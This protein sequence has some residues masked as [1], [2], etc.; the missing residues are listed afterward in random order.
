MWY[1][2]RYFLFS[3]IIYWLTS[4]LISGMYSTR[5]TGGSTLVTPCLLQEVSGYDIERRTE[6]CKGTTGPNN[7]SPNLENYIVFVWRSIVLLKWLIFQNL[8]T[9]ENYRFNFC[10]SWSIVFFVLDMII[11]KKINLLILRWMLLM[12]SWSCINSTTDNSLI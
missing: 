9:L 10:R 3:T 4:C 6:F 1:K 5:S 2:V 11:S 8:W 12:N 7:D